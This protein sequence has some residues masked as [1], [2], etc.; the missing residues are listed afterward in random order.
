MFRYYPTLKTNHSVISVSSVAKTAQDDGLY[1]RIFKNS[2]MLTAGKAYT[3][4]AG[5]VYLALATRALGAHN[6]GVL[7]LIHAY[8]VAVRDLITLKTAQ[9]VVR[10]GAL[11]LER[12]AREDFQKLVK[13]TMLLDLV[14]CVAAALAG[15]LAVPLVGPW[16]GVT[17]ELVPVATLYC[18]MILFN[19]KTTSLGLLRLFDRF[20][21]V[22]LMLMLVP[23]IRLAG[24]CAAYLFYQHVGAFLL[25]WFSAGALQCFVTIWFGWREFSRRGFSKDMN[26]SLKN[27]IKPHE[28]II[29]FIWASH[30][31]KTLLTSSVHIATLIV[32]ALS[33]PASAGLF[34]IAQE[35]AAVLVKPARLFT[36]T[37]Y[38]E[39]TKIA[40]INNFSRLWNIIKHTALVGGAIAGFFLLLVFLFGD[41]LLGLFFGA[42][43]ASAYD[44]LVLMMIGAAITMTS[45]ALDPAL[46]SI[47]RPDISMYVRVFT[48]ILQITALVL[49]L[50]EFGLVG[51][52]LAVIAG[53]LATALLLLFYTNR[54]VKKSA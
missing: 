54:L 22:A 11:C 48:T 5:L 7:I 4:L 35:S 46:F 33:G 19:F 32:G 25:F 20:D 44:I 17:P 34:K 52:G 21:L 27:L 40:V 18:L 53:S 15:M 38:P 51:A 45:F 41:S 30:V 6:F 8:A 12:N 13:F 49:L 14:F 39:M 37:V 29:S 31:N 2:A 24:A 16:F 9:S 23:T 26:L 10:Y 28:G 36:E 1:G 42:E 3:A 43:Y 50:P 47:G